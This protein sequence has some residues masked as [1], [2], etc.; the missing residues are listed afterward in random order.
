MQKRGERVFNVTEVDDESD[1]PD[2]DENIAEGLEA[3]LA[4][5]RDDAKQGSSKKKK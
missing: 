5:G 2:S 3:I 1:N 4:L